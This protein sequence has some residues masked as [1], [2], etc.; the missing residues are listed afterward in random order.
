MKGIDTYKPLK[1]LDRASFETSKAEEVF[2]RRYN[3]WR[4]I[5][6]MTPRTKPQQESQERVR[7]LFWSQKITPLSIWAVGVL[8]LVKGLGMTHL[9]PRQKVFTVGLTLGMAQFWSNYRMS[10]KIFDLIGELPDEELE[11]QRQELMYETAISEGTFIK[12]LIHLFG[13]KNMEIRTAAK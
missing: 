13:A 8:L 10:T 6:K 9:A 3:F 11:K 1:S 12:G 5:L 2:V 4:G 7:R